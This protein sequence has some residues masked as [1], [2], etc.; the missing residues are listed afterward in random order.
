MAAAAK[1][2]NTGTVSKQIAK[3]TQDV[4]YDEILNLSGGRKVKVSIRSDSYAF[5]SHARAS[6][7]DGS[8]W[9]VVHSVHHS[10]MK[11]PSGLYYKSGGDTEVHFQADRAELLRVVEAVTKP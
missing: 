9:H 7:W 5:Q 1:K 6:L 4:V 8:K 3:G 2:I 11:T 10:L